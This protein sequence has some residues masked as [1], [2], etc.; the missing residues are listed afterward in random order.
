VID[1]PH[2]ECKVVPANAQAS[3]ARGFL[4]VGSSRLILIEAPSATYRGGMLALGR[5]N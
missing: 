2:P 4:R 5:T 1:M 3:A